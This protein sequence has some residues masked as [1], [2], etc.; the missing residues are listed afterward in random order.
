MFDQYKNRLGGEQDG[1]TLLSE[2]LGTDVSKILY[3][4]FGADL[5]NFTEQ[6]IKTNITRCCVTQ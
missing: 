3:S 1:T 4:N 2:C 5:S 6:D